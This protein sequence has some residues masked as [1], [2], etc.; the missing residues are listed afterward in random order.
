MFMKEKTL[1]LASVSID[2]IDKKGNGVGSS[3]LD[4]TREI[5]V[6]VPFAIPGDIIKAK[7]GKKRKG[8]YFGSIDEIEKAS[9]KRQEARCKHFGV[10]GGC[11]WQQMPYNEQLKIKDQLVKQIFEPLIND[12][13]CVHSIIP[14]DPNWGYRNKMEYSFSED[15]KGNRYLGLIQDSSRGK[16]LN[17]TECHLVPPWF[18][19]CMQEVREW[20]KSSNLKAYH[21][22]SDK[23]SLRTLTL[24]EGVRLGDRM[25]ILTVS[26]NPEYVLSSSDIEDFVNVIINSSP[27]EK[28]GGNWSIFLRIQQVAKGMA[29]NF[30]EMHLYGADYIR[31]VLYLKEIPEPFL[32]HI[33]PTA[34][35]QPSLLQAE[36]LYSRVIELADIKK[37]SIVYDLYCGTG[38]LGIIAAKRAK[39]VVGIEVCPEAALDAKTNAKL[40]EID[41]TTIFSGAVRHVLSQIK[42]EEKIGLPDIILIDPPRPGIDPV[43]MREIL[44]LSTGK[45]VY[46]SCNPYT[47]FNDVKEFLQNGWKIESLQP[48]DQFAQTPHVE[49]ICVL[50]R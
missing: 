13:T 11:R 15:I 22:Y 8:A 46:V 12:K 44:T 24:R 31:E 7:L 38:T 35:F 45:I 17:L 28:R 40:N 10:C 39:H 9:S 26:G 23:G 34:F 37:D 41:N 6:V 2:S 20:W 14:C 48:V 18:T 42:E 33:S 30:Y 49:N 27:V 29:T 50:S 32:F 1:R 47:Q 5:E 25:A 16:V 3:L 19:N 43:A 36:K 4:D 21:P